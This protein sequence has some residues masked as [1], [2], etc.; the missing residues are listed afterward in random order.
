MEQKNKSRILYIQK[1]LYEKTDEQNPLSTVEIINYLADIGINTHRRT[2]AADM[3]LLEEFGIDVITIK[4]TQNKYFIG[5]REFEL[6]EIKVLVDAV[7]SSKFI[8]A[9]K[10]EELVKKLSCLTSE[11]QATELNRHI[12]IDKRI[13]PENEEIYYIIDTIHN[14]IAEEKQIEFK[15]YEYT[16]DKQK[17]YK[18]NGYLYKLSPYALSW[19]EDHY[20]VIG[21]CKKHG[22]ISKFRVD[23]MAKPKMLDRKAV[24]MPVDFNGAD[25]AKKI[26]EMYDGEM[27]TVEI[28]C[29]NELMKVIIDRFGEDVKTK[30]LGSTHFKAIIDISVSPTFYGWVFQFASKMSILTPVE[31]KEEYMKMAKKILGI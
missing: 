25:Y 13:K 22:K 6:P 4:S 9:K 21:Y 16:Q 11:K 29:A 2:I 18:N 24:L 27:K 3:E 19:S 1:L 17:V 26:F 31:V 5:S 15:Y 28:K 23:R 14:A 7:E 12:Y 20:Y 30:S 8:T 10:S